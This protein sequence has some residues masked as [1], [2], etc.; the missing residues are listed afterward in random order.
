MQGQIAS[1]LK[2]QYITPIIFKK[3]T[4]TDAINYIRTVSL[5]L[6]ITKSFELIVRKQLVTYLEASGFIS[7]SQ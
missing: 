2:T 6:N 1:C 3:G 4:G 5:T 7:T